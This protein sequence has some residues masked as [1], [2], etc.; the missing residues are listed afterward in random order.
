MERRN[1]IRSLNKLL[2]R[3]NLQQRNIDYP[4]SK[5][6]RIYSLQ[7]TALVERR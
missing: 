5:A 1:H 7:E 2:A 6:L 3:Y 4:K